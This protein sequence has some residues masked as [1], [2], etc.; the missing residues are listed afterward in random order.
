M[1][2]KS[3]STVR[4]NEVDT[5]SSKKYV[6]IRRNV[7]EYVD[8]YGTTIYEYDEYKVPKDVYDIFRLQ[9][10]ASARIDDIE[11]TIV[12]MLGGGI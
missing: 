8:E 6:Y 3:Q 1:W 2:E 4:P 9:N 7:T 11:E 5:T 10:E 12:E